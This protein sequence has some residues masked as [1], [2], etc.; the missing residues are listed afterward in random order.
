[1]KDKD[2]MMKNLNKIEKWVTYL[3]NEYIFYDFAD[4]IVALL[5]KRHK[6]LINLKEDDQ[7]LKIRSIISKLMLVPLK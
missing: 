1:M 2:V 3:H 7:R 4:I 5:V 6:D